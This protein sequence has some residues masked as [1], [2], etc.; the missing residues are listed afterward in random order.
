MGDRGSLDS[1]KKIFWIYARG[2]AILE[3]AELTTTVSVIVALMVFTA[4]FCLVLRLFS[5]VSI[6]GARKIPRR[7]PVE[8]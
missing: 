4:L 1:S 7:A 3:N 6:C 8:N 5:K 2:V